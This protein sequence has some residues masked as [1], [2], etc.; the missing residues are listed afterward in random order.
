MVLNDI[1]IREMMKAG[2]IRNANDDQVNPS[3][4]NVRLAGSFA[5]P[6]SKL[7]KLGDKVRYVEYPF[8]SQFVINPGDFILAATMEE[9]K[10]PDDISAF[11]QGR[12]S[13]GRI[14]LSVQ[15]AGFV[16]PGFHGT[17]TL[18]LKNDS[19]NAIILTA[20]Y[21]IAQ[22]VFMDTAM[23]SR[24]YSGKYNG[25]VD[26]TGSRMHLDAKLHQKHAL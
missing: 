26:A 24:P 25:Q 11:V 19:K 15:N 20:G 10:I 12:S 23:V 22:L 14:G 21:P 5:I 17:I 8:A 18:E 7:V 13:I 6:V 2:I 4:I 3:S 1:Q 16:D 9:F